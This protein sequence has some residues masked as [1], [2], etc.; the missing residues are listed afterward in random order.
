MKGVIMLLCFDYATKNIGYTYGTDDTPTV[1]MIAYPVVVP[2]K[3]QLSYKTLSA[4]YAYNLK[5]ILDLVERVQ[6]TMIIFESPAGMLNA[7]GAVTNGSTTMLITAMSFLIK[8]PILTFTPHQIKKVVQHIKVEGTPQS[9][10]K[11]QG[12]QWARETFPT[13]ALPRAIAKAEHMAD[14]LILYHLA[15]NMLRGEKC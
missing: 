6:P 13:V 11:K 8:Q 9:K 1:G 2:K 15:R 12:V 14:S 5:E 4:N 10:R 3:D 7:Y